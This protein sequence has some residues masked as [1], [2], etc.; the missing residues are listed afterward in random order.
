MLEMVPDHFYGVE[1][2]ASHR[3]KEHPDA[4]ALEVLHKFGV[5]VT[6]EIVHD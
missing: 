2:A 3:G 5:F 4:M 6:V 1:V